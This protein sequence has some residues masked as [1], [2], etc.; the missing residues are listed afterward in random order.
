MESRRDAA[1][2]IGRVLLGVI[3][4]TS[5]F[6][7]LT[8]LD[9][10]AASLAKNGV[11]MSGALA[12]L[13][14]AVEFFGGLAVVLGVRTCWTAGLM[15]LFVIVATLISHRYWEF[16]D[17]ARRMQQVQFNKNLAIIGGFIL[18]AACG[19]GRFSVDALLR[20][21]KAP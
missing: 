12:I 17:A 1:L 8:N 9:G 7:K 4:V 3:F 10:F 11:P 19:G 13:G 14:A 5:G 6:G 18:L 15:I 21:K 16:A 20:R 2:L